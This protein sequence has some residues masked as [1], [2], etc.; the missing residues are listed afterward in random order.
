MPEDSLPPAK[1]PR[2]P[3]PPPTKR[4]P[5][6]PIAIPIEL[7]RSFFITASKM[8]RTSSVAMR[9]N[10][11]YQKM[12]R[13]DAD[14]EGVLRSLQV[15]LAG[16][17]WTVTA[18]DAS[19]ER[20]QELCVAVKK[21]IR[22]A[23]RLTDMFRHLHEAVW[24]GCSAVNVIYE[25]SDDGIVIA[26]WRPFHP[27]TLAFDQWGNMA[28]RVGSSYYN[29]G[30]AVTDIGF[31]SRVHIFDESERKAVVFHR[32]FSVPPD[33]DDPWVTDRQ[34]RGF[35]ARDVA[36]FMWLAKQEVLQDA[37]TFA[38]RYAVGIRKGWYPMGN[39]E[40]RAVMED[41][42][43]NLVNDNSVLLPK[44]GDDKLFDIEIM[45]PAGG[46]NMSMFMDLVNWLSGKLKESIVGQS[47]S[48]E[49]GSTG[50]GSG[51]ADL[52]GS[53]L[54]HIIR[55][56]A[57]ALA[58]SITRDLVRN[59]AKMVGATDTESSKI[60]FRF[61]EER[62]DIKDRLEALQRYIEMGGEVIDNEVRDMLGLGDPKP[63]E[64]VLGSKRAAQEGMSKIDS[65]APKVFS[66]RI[67]IA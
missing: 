58:D 42:L 54:S 12:M 21:V 3:L 28:M 30:W 26:E 23:P 46:G 37:L 19:D 49:A 51:V 55:F 35:G 33:F 61:S 45:E 65:I 32:S 52:H 4:E 59:V 39:A 17:N 67:T 10:P 15:T 64:A 20:L 6:Q 16:L 22:S 11:E 48:S 14:I 27:D 31:D 34:Y 40:G 18:D 47:L 7:Q 8:L 41:V 57:D 5:T 63:G 53:T 66:K 9:L 50:L 2:K 13:Y 29:D 38:E 36:W 56:H 44:T 60:M 43:A 25:R 1:R 62:V 24:Y